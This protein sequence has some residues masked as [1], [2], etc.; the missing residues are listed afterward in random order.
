MK[1]VSYF[2]DV[3][4]SFIEIY[5]AYL[6]FGNIFKIRKKAVYT[7]IIMAIVGVFLVIFCNNMMLFSYVT[8]ILVWI[9]LSISARM[10]YKVESVSIISISGFY[11]LCMN[12][13]DFLIATVISNLY[14]GEIIQKIVSQRGLTRMMIIILVKLIWIL[15]YMYMRKYL[16][17]ITINVKV[18]VVILLISI[19]GFCGFIFASNETIQEFN[20][21]IPALWLIGACLLLAIML[22]IYFLTL[23]NQEKMKIRYLE[24]GNR[25]LTEK[26]DS[27]YFRAGN[28]P[29]R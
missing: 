14:E 10:L 26:Y 9:Y 11:L 12:C 2:V 19:I 7:E 4:A 23:Q 6:V 22:V 1:I 20:H 13:V 27:I 29:F 21:M 8:I 24:F 5:T 17:K 3:L 25:L 28:L 18:S 16:C 15:I